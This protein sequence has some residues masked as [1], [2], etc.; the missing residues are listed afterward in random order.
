MIRLALFVTLV[1][2]TA[3]AAYAQNPAS[4]ISSN[5]FVFGAIAILGLQLAAVLVIAAKVRGMVRTE[6]R[7]HVDARLLDDDSAFG[8]HRKDALAHEPMR[9][10]L[11]QEIKEGFDKVTVQMA[12]MEKHHR[13]EMRNLTDILKPVIEQNTFLTR[14]MAAQMRRQPDD[15]SEVERR[16]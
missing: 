12:T 1:A 8:K 2:L 16:A 15:E 9:R 5:G 13:D 4:G 14:V 6:V 10:Q 11:V 3:T 7:E